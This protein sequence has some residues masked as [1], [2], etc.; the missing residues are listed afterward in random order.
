MGVDSNM[1]ITYSPTYAPYFIT[2]AE[3][4]I[5]IATYKALCFLLGI[6]QTLSLPELY[7][8]SNETN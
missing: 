2:S 3:K 5:G 6:S 8:N 1:A 4:R 7:P